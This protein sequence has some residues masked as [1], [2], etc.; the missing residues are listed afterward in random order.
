MEHRLL[1]ALLGNTTSKQFKFG[2]HTVEIRTLTKKEYD[3]VVSR[4]VALNPVA[5][6]EL[7]K[8]PLLG[9]ALTKI[10]DANILAFPEV[11]KLADSHKGVNANFIVEEYLG[12]YNS[13]I[14]DVLYTMYN[15]IETQEAKRYEEIKKQLADH[16]V[17]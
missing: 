14:I 4:V 7:I 2:E 15:V 9:Y 11:A 6:E 13:N 3:E 1:D 17:G 16:L 8:R 12:E 10:D 5:H